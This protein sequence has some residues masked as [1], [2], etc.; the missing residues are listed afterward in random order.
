MTI[1]PGLGQGRSE[2]EVL[3]GTFPPPPPPLYTSLHLQSGYNQCI[4]GLANNT[5]TKCSP[6]LE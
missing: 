6:S 4:F 1:L 2:P 5:K 3:S